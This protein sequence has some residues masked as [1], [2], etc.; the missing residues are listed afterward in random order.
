MQMF[1]TFFAPPG[2]TAEN[3]HTLGAS[4]NVAAASGWQL[5]SYW[6]LG[7]GKPLRAHCSVK[8]LRYVTVKA[9][10]RASKRISF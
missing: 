8:I 2:I 3:G 4:G 5:L 6:T 1:E 7:Y 9:N 10:I